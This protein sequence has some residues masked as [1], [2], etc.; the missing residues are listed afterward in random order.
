MHDS[1]RLFEF[2]CELWFRVFVVALAGRPRRPAVASG[3]ES[4]SC[5]KIARVLKAKGV[6]YESVREGCVVVR[7]VNV[8][9]AISALA[10]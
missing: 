3:D 1:P 8:L 5:F 2:G 6:L 10:P 4:S 7:A 9:A